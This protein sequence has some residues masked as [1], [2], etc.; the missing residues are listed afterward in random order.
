MD[1]HWLHRFFKPG[2][3][4][5]V[6]A[7]EDRTRFGFRYLHN[8]LNFGRRDRVYPVNPR[9]T[10]CLGLRCYASIR[11]LP[12]TP[13]HVGI[14]VA[15][16]RVPAVIA[17]CVARGVP[18]A[19][20]FTG[21]FAELGTQEGKAA[22]TEI[23]AQARAGGLRLMGPN[24][25]GAIN[26]IDRIPMASTATVGEAPAPAGDIAIVGNSGGLPQVNVMWRAQQLG[27][28]ISHEVS[29]GNEADL[30]IADFIDFFVHD[31]DT[32]VILVAAERIKSG[33][34]FLNAARA[35]SAAEKPIV[36]LKLGRSDAGRRAAE[37]HTG[38]IAGADAIADAALRQ[39]GILR[40][41]DTSELYEAA[42]ALRDRRR[43]A[44]NRASAVSVSGG[45]N[46]LIADRGAEFG[47]AFPDFA[48]ATHAKL[49][50]LIPGY[51]RLGNPADMSSAALGRQDMQRAIM[52]TIAAD[53]NI[54]YL[55][56]VTTLQSERDVRAAAAIV[57][58]CAKPAALLWTGGT[59]D[60]SALGPADLIRI[61]IP[62]YR[63]IGAGL[64]AIAASMRHAAFRRRQARAS[65]PERPAGID[66]DAAARLLSAAGERLGER[67]TKALL[68][69]YGLP[70][71]REALALDVEEALR[72]AA[73]LG[74]GKVALKIEAEGVAHKSEIGGVRL[75]LAGDA[76]IRAGFAGLLADAR[77]AI[78]HARISGVIVQ[79]MRAPGLEM[80]LGIVRDASLGPAI[81]VGFGGVF[82]ELLADLAYRLP[83]IAEDEAEAMLQELRG[84]RLLEG[85]RGRPP[86]DRVALRDA[87]MRLSWLAAD[88]GDR[89][90]ELDVNPLIVGPPGT[91]ACVV[92]GWARIDG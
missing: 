21:G 90:A 19:T 12:E 28:G 75:D 3:M 78:P 22:Q 5:I 73:A 36:M 81:A 62:V 76:E 23:V 39:L 24:C 38:A 57:A 41:D 54:D 79:E 46:A 14:I 86:A 64:R 85:I 74:G 33:P 7:T 80:L 17:D 63:D 84:H 87:I 49:A 47:V 31:P 77:R 51:I 8:I 52:E 59:N 4:A 69:A 65:R 70:V 1:R 20:I 82:V 66:R 56:P 37:S 35:A 88:F 13:D 27:L 89:I 68:A 53:P 11:D 72:H 10:T 45:N 61:G 60:G 18:F 91:G 58:E 83:P 55:I 40:V 32:R 34:G 29:C 15:A 2:A 50:T 16:E 92:D 9:L 42:M 67:Q 43:P 6:G 71:A 26:F 30:E 25:N 48:E 44:G